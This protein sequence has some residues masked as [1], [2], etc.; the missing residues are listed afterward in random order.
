MFKYIFKVNK[1]DDKT[2][3]WQFSM[4][5]PFL[6]LEKAFEWRIVYVNG[7]P[8]QCSKPYKKKLDSHK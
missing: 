6:I 7:K 4:E 5:S 3:P 1:K 8:V 2:S